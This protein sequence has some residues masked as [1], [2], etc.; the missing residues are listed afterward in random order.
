[1]NQKHRREFESLAEAAERTGLSTK[2]LRRRIASGVL[3]A[4]RSGP[5]VLRVD[6]DDVDR[7]MVRLPTVSSGSDTLR[8]A[9]SPR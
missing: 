2:T 4:Y 8:A 6:P 9:H 5:R 1:M 7:M 3:A